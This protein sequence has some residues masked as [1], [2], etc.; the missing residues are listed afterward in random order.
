MELVHQAFFQELSGQDAA[1][2]EKDPAHSAGGEFMEQV[3]K[4]ASSRA[5]WEVQ[6][7]YAPDGG[8]FFNHGPEHGLP[9]YG[10]PDFPSVRETTL[11]VQ[12]N[13]EG[14]AVGG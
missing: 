4:T 9:G 11:A 13:P 1:P 5:R 6:I 7:F 3:A 14:L 8:T 12:H 10:E 2:F